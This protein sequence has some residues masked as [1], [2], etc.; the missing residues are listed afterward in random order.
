MKH[1]SRELKRAQRYGGTVSILML[2]IDNFKRV[3]DTYGHAIGDVVLERFAREARKSLQRATDWCARIGGEEFAVVLEGATLTD[4]RFR[5]E[6]IRRC[7]A[8]CSIETPSGA[9]RITVSIGVSGLEAISDRRSATVQALMQHAD[10]N[11]FSSKANGRNCVTLSAYK[12]AP[13]T[14]FRAAASA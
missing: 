2:D 5:A 1:F 9:V 8:K 7:I 6:E 3:N 13:D 14:P 4:A 12:A 10:S 11:L